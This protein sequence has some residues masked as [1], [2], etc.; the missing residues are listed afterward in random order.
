MPDSPEL[1]QV[2]DKERR[3]LKEAVADL[4]GEIEETKERGKRA[5]V[6]ATGTAV[7][8]RLFYAALKRRKRAEL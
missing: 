3:E 6:F 4:V 1:R 2:V 7:A 8:A 5:L